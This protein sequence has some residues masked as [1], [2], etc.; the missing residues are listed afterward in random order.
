VFS[1]TT[2]EPAV[3]VRLEE[4]LPDEIRKDLRELPQR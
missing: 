3:T 4:K 2:K 1:Q